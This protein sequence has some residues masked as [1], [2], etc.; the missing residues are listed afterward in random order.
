MT[1]IDRMRAFVQGGHLAAL[2]ETEKNVWLVLHQFMNDQPGGRAFAGLATLARLIGHKDRKRIRNA[3][4]ELVRRGYLILAEPATFTTPNRY[5]VTVP[6][7]LSVP[8]SPVGLSAPQ[9][10]DS[11]MGSLGPSPCRAERPSPCRAL[12]PP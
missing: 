12:S 3:I 9:G 10:T 8:E 1:H 2:N 5:I 11:P 7:P 4:A 6:D